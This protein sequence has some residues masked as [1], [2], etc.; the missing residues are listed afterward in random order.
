MKIKV[1]VDMSEF[2]E[3]FNDETID[4]L[5]SDIIKEEIMKKV[6]RDEKYK[7]FVAKQAV[8]ILDGLQI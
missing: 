8:K 5:I 6:K 4:A 3:T 2:Y 7:A 1:E